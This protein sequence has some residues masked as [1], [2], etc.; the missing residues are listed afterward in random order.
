M[1]VNAGENLVSGCVAVEEVT[2]FPQRWLK[3]FEERVG[4]VQSICCKICRSAAEGGHGGVSLGGV[5][6]LDE[7]AESQLCSP[8]LSLLLC[9]PS[10]LEVETVDL[11]ADR[12][13][14]SVQR[15][16]L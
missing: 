9:R 11:H 12:K 6:E 3:L 5:G 13:Q 10:A 8:H 4:E 14:R 7:G 1:V 2:V 15:A 16:G